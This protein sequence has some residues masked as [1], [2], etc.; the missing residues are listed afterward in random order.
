MSLDFGVDQKQ[1]VLERI[2]ELFDAQIYKTI[3]K[4]NKEIEVNLLNYGKQVDTLILWL[5]CDREGEN[6]AYEVVDV[7]RS[8]NSRIN[9]LR[10]HFSAL[11][12][13]DIE[14]AMATLQRPNKNLSDAVDIRQN[15]D[16]IIGAS[17][18][19]LQ[20]LSFQ[21]IILREQLIRDQKQVISYGPCQFPTLN[22]IVER[23]EK[24]RNFKP[25]EFYYIDLKIKGLAAG[26]R[27]QDVDFTWKRNRLFDKMITLTLYECVMDAK[28]AKVISV[29]SNPRT[30][31]RPYPLNTVD[32]QKLISRKLRINSHEAMDIAEKLYQ[33]GFISYPRTETQKFSRNENLK[34]LVEE[35]TISN[36]WGRFA[37]NILS[38]IIKAN[39]R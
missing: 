10:A 14:R 24:I 6:I 9:I 29:N 7:V 23:T 5:D 36:E 30:R 11:T 31:F 25:E 8:V 1:W 35:Q 16:L 4:D 38:G 3:T 21:P 19:R 15:I 34:K 20:S 13:K 12:P 28:V 22:F 18:T 33:K 27:S 37:Q 2:D 26:E 39:F 32:M 17:F